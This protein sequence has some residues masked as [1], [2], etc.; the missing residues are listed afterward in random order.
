MDQNTKARIL[1]RL[2][3]GKHIMALDVF[4]KYVQDKN[5]SEYIDRLS[6]LKS[7]YQQ[8]LRSVDAMET[9]KTLIF[10]EKAKLEVAI[11]KIITEVEEHE[12]LMEEPE[13]PIQDEKDEH[14]KDFGNKIL[15]LAS[16]PWDTGKLQLEKEFVNIY[17]SLSEFQNSFQLSAE[18]AVSPDSLQLSVLK[19]QPSIL[20]FSGHG[21]NPKKKEPGIYLENAQGSHQHV[22]ARALS[23]LFK[24]ISR[25]NP[26]DIVVFNACYSV[27]QA[28]AILDH[29]KY[30]IGVPE[31]LADS[32]ALEFAKGF[33]RGLASEGDIEFAFDLGL[34]KV[35]LES[36]EKE[37]P[38]DHLPKLIPNQQ[39]A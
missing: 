30:V 5:L 36:G 17:N 7:R 29:V 15:F 32:T 35:L 11:K 24:L 2:E 23:H 39:K 14:N 25:K 8:I 9:E 10:S 31:E 13:D 3:K 1:E 12:A 38:D 18:W 28:D 6:I 26:I 34:N 33:Y 21:A 37:I 4:I 22:Q 16:N 20:H 27:S 19:Q